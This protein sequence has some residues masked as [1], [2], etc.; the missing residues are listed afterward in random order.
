MVDDD[1]CLIHGCTESNA[2]NYVPYATFDD[3]TCILPKFGC[4]DPDAYNYRLKAN[5]DDGTSALESE[6]C[7]FDV[8]PRCCCNEFPLY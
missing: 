4:M 8:A 2:F 6:H 1:G 3:G 7:S 5:M